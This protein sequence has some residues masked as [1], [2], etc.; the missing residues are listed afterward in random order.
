LST[1]DDLTSGQGEYVLVVEYDAAQGAASIVLYNELAMEFSISDTRICDA[2][3]V[4][5][6]RE[7]GGSF[8]LRKELFL[9]RA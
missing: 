4:G 7:S 6:S 5:R 1:F 3:F 2:R 9:C 8:F